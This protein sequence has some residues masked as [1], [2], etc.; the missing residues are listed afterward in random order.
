MITHIIGFPNY[1]LSKKGR[2]YSLK[3]ERFLNPKF[4]N[5]RKHIEL[6]RYGKR[7]DFYIH[8]LLATHFLKEYPTQEGT[9]FFL[10][11]NRENTTLKN[12]VFIPSDY[13]RSILQVETGK[14]FKSTTEAA[15]ITGIRKDRILLV[16]KRRRRSAGNS[17]WKFYNQETN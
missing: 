9:I 7:K 12:L 10:D 1:L 4:K 14:V 13:P 15:K 8:E 6:H 5:G 3:S 11:G 2:V 16:C 17:T